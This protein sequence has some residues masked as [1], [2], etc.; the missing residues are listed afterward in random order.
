MVTARADLPVQQVVVLVVLHVANPPRQSTVGMVAMLVLAVPQSALLRQ[1][2]V[3]RT[4]VLRALAVT[5]A[6]QVAAEAAEVGKAAPETSARGLVKLV[7]LVLMPILAT[8]VLVERRPALMAIRERMVP[9]LR[10]P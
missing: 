10:R 5:A 6:D 7:R 3:M 9:L 4:R 2:S 1:A 8:A